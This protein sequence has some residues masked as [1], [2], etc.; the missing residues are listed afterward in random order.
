[1]NIRFYKP[2]SA[3]TRHRSISQFTQKKSLKAKTLYYGHHRP[4][5]RNNRGVITI[6]HRGGGHKRLYRR[7]DF[8]R[9]I[10]NM[11]AKVT[12]IHYDPNRNARIALLTYQNNAMR[13]ILCPH[14]V[15]LGTDIVAKYTAPIQIGNALPLYN[16]PLGTPIHNVELKPGQGGK[17][18]RSAGTVARLIAKE[19]KW[20][21]IRLPSSEIR[22]LPIDCWATIGQVSNIIA[23]N[24]TL[25]KAGA[26]RWQGKR[27][28]VRGSVMN[29]AD[30]P[31]GGGEGRAPIGRSH[32]MTPW[33][34]IAIGPHTR[35]NKKY[36]DI[37]ITK[38]RNS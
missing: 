18:V 27:P 8:Q 12:A 37:F 36:S 10:T 11:Y 20:A 1:M 30:H 17:L 29:A 28:H 23:N 35:K 6:R 24:V 31:H 21:S 38:R 7:I 15:T 9:N 22:L 13:Y 5:G 33:G 26:K 19:G 25:G 4:K 14:N 3:G 34:K 32:A 16:I 2:C